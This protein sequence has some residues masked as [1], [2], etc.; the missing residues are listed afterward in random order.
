MAI[1]L[2]YKNISKQDGNWKVSVN[3]RPGSDEMEIWLV[4]VVLGKPQIANINKDGFL[5][6][7]DIK[8]D[9]T[10]KPFMR[11]PMQVWQLLVDAITDS[12]PPTKKEV[13]EA[14]LES[15][16]YHLEDMRKLV[17]EKPKQVIQLDSNYSCAHGSCLPGKCNYKD[18]IKK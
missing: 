6:L 13:V 14:Q 5:L 10:E 3:P 4:N 9:G 17:F 2:H 15:V 16:K 11:V 8:E 7:T 18:D 12:T 1:N